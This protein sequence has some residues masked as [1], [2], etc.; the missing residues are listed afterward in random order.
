MPKIDKYEVLLI[1]KKNNMF[2]IFS[3]DS[4]GRVLMK[5]ANDVG[6]LY[7]NLDSLSEL[8]YKDAKFK[9]ITLLEFYQ[10]EIINNPYMDKIDVTFK[11]MIP[12]MYAFKRVTVAFSHTEITSLLYQKAE[13]YDLVKE[14][15]EIINPTK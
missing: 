10:K 9:L 4:P 7:K 2:G 6:H 11:C 15:K 1:R 12:E 5:Y 14:F 13:E 3:K 8:T